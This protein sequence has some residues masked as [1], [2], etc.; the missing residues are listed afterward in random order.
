MLAKHSLP[1]P[2]KDSSSRHSVVF[3]PGNPST[4]ELMMQHIWEKPHLVP[5]HPQVHG[6]QVFRQKLVQQRV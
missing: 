6:A 1:K 3:E 5:E 4:C 2:I